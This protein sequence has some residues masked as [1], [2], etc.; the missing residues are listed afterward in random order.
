[1]KK[2]PRVYLAQIL[3]RVDRILSFTESGKDGFLSNPLIQ[4]AVMLNFEVIG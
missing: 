2:D 3:E 1:M 4:D